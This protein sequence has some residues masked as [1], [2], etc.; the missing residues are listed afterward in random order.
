MFDVFGLVEFTWKEMES[1]GKKGEGAGKLRGAERQ[2][3]TERGKAEKGRYID[4]TM[5]RRERIQIKEGRDWVGRQEKE[6]G[7]FTLKLWAEQRTASPEKYQERVGACDRKEWL[8]G[9][10][11]K[12]MN[13]DE[14]DKSVS[15]SVSIVLFQLVLHVLAV[16][17][18]KTWYCCKN[19]NN[20]LLRCLYCHSV[21]WLVCVKTAFPFL[22]F[23][24]SQTLAACESLCLIQPGQQWWFKARLSASAALVQSALLSKIVCPKQRSPWWQPQCSAGSSDTG[25]ECA[26]KEWLSGFRWKN[27]KLTETRPHKLSVFSACCKFTPL[28][29]AGL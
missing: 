16:K 22:L 29:I 20:S 10:K 19:L 9:G 11:G 18:H 3:T 1:Q 23:Y 2:R 14:L 8:V 21:T 7:A 25:S 17:W 26:E 15:L 4:W 27:S 6:E 13:H 12:V 5:E 24:F 28:C